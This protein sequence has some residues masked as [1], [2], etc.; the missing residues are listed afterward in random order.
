MDLIPCEIEVGIDPRVAVKP[1]DAP[2]SMPPAA[3]GGED[4]TGIS[5][6]TDLATNKQV[7]INELTR[8]GSNNANVA[9]HL[10]APITVDATNY[11]VRP[12]APTV[13]VAKK[14]K[15]YESH[16]MWQAENAMTTNVQNGQSWKWLRM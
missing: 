5:L 8:K 4:G 9:T 12:W 6:Q 15:R 1:H 14:R 11:R 16:A 3:A 13:V 10:R 7:H 2:T